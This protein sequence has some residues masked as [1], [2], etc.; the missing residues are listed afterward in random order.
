VKESFPSEKIVGHI[1][2]QENST[3]IRNN[4]GKQGTREGSGETAKGH[5][6]K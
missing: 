5:G 2:L 1:W 4:T 3:N 6:H